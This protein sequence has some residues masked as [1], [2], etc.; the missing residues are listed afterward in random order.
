MKFALLGSGSQ[1]NASLVSAGNTLLLIDCGFSLRTLVQRMATI[2]LQPDQLTAVLVTHEHADHIRGIGPLSRKY[3]LPIYL[4]QG[5]AQS[6]ALG[7]LHQ[8]HIISADKTLVLGDIQV[9]VN[10]VPHDAR[11]PVQFIFNALSKRLGLLTDTGSIPDALVDKYKQLDALI[12][13]ANYCPEMLSRGPYPPSLKERVA[14]SWG[15]LS[16]HQCVDLVEQL[17]IEQ[18][19]HLVLAHISQ[20]NNS[21]E[22]V[23]A[24]FEH[25]PQVRSRL[26]LAEQDDGFAWLHI[27]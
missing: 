23:L 19:Q 5:T 3:Q 26:H 4:T 17:D 14:G 22:R 15:H 18:L 20:K 16:N 6:K 27:A 11:E 2:N 7:V 21:A 12:L 10:A 9:E 13:E 25:I 1:G 8:K 24:V